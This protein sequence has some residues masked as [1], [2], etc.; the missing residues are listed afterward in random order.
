MWHSF[1]DW[2]A[3]PP[4]AQPSHAAALRQHCAVL[5]PQAVADATGRLMRRLTSE[6]RYA[7]LAPMVQRTAVSR[8][9][10]HQRRFP[11]RDAARRAVTQAVKTGALPRPTTLVCADCGKPAKE[12]DHYKGYAEVNRLIVQPVCIRCHKK[13]PHSKYTVTDKVRNRR[14]LDPSEGGNALVEQRGREYMSELGRKSAANRDPEHYR[15]MAAASAIARR[16]LM[17]AG[18]AALAKK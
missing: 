16:R 4:T 8:Q 12:Y 7:L 5:G 3:C 6:R 9:R 14:T 15:R 10:E 18:R 13:R 2:P 11:D 17:D 1:S